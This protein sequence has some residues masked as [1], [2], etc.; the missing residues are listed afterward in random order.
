MAIEKQ[1]EMELKQPFFSKAEYVYQLLKDKIANGYLERNKIYTIVEIAHGLGI[2]RTPVGEAVK[3]L[4]SRKYIILYQGV[5]FKVK[6]L[7]K[8]DIREN[9]TITGALEMAVLK[10]IIQDGT[11]TI[12]KLQEAVAKSWRAMKHKTPMLYTQSSAEFH[13]AF[14][15]LAAWP[16]VT[17]IL[18]ENV[19]VHEIWY[20]EGASCYPE[21]IKR[22][23]GDHE[24]IIKII[25]HA[26]YDRIGKVINAHVENCEEV[27]LK[28]IQ[29]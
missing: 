24:N 1:P 10:K 18:H 8:D 19:F 7:T 5:G 6:E 13:K 11:N 22:L 15:A 12:E 29:V 3:I 23:I 17:E 16:R 14:Y 21:G 2:S 25:K 28:V 27:L 4:A 26:D 20:R 9:L